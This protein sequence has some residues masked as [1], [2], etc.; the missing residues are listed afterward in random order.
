[1]ASCSAMAMS[2]CRP[3]VFPVNV[4]R[5]FPKGV[6]GG[7]TKIENSRSS[8]LSCSLASA[9]PVL[10]KNSF[11]KDMR[12]VLRAS[13]SSARNGRARGRRFRDGKRGSGRCSWRW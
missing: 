8:P 13:R 3:P 12:L 6:F 4:R 9:A 7:S 10:E 2:S 1:M 5:T 11:D